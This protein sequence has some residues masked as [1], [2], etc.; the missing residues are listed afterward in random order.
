MNFDKGDL[1][2]ITFRKREV[3]RRVYAAVRDRNWG[4]ILGT[5]AN[6][7][8]DSGRD[9]FNVSY[10]SEHLQGDISFVWHAEISGDSS[11]TI[12][13]TFDGEARSTFLKNRIGLCVLHPMEFAGSPVKLMR[14][15]GT[16]LEAQFPKLVAQEQPIKNVHD[17]RVLSHAIAP[18][19]WLEFQFEGD[20]FETEDQRN[21]ID[22]SFKTYS[23][24]QR[25]PIPVEIQRGTRIQQSVTIKLGG[26]VETEPVEVIEHEPITLTIDLARERP[27]PKIGFGCSSLGKPYNAKTIERLKALKP[28]HLRADLWMGELNWPAV[29]REA[30]DLGVP[31][32]IVLRLSQE[33]TPAGVREALPGL[34]KD[35]GV[36]VSKWIIYSRGEKS[37]TAEALFSARNTL[38]DAIPIGVGTDADFYQLN[39]Q[40]PPWES[41]DF[42]AWSMNP[43][44]HAFDNLSIAET[45][46]AVPSQIESART[47]FPGKP[48]HISPITLKPRFNPVATTAEAGSRAG[49]LPP[50]VDPRQSFL[51]AAAWTVGMLQ[52]LA[53]SGADSVTFFETVGW[54]GIVERDAGASLPEKFKSAPGGVY[55]V[56]LPFRWIADVG[57]AAVVHS[58]LSR[59]RA[60]SA[61]LLRAPDRYRLLLANLTREDQYI[62]PIGLPPN[63]NFM[64]V[65]R[66]D[67]H[68][69]PLVKQDVEEWTDLMGKLAKMQSG[70]I[71]YLPS[72][73]L[74]PQEIVCVDFLSRT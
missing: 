23:T 26:R 31:L 38:G 71:E 32:E 41:A 1:R 51:F 37:T 28:A 70:G 36:T 17:L 62:K 55:P 39:Q 58:E 19:A 20:L 50:D 6:L 34:L 74:T 66:F 40:R 22:A 5:L 65:A 15:D 45:P 27:L 53:Q 8:I 44:V 14:A 25:L 3:V 60:V 9:F 30:R 63:S 49:E 67:T 68:Y 61:M 52:Q 2:Y 35:F 54:R 4:T 33:Q 7:K 29:F 57:S 24:P 72:I 12:R 69:I 42:V 11:G 10:D 64:F 59:T 21:W 46:E 16:K 56:Y 48:L 43:Q 13:F 73:K 18:D 47:Y